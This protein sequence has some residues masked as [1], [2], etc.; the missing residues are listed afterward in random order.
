MKYFNATICVCSLLLCIS[1]GIQD[2][3][4]VNIYVNEEVTSLQHFWR[5][6]G[7]CPPLPHANASSFLLSNDMLQ[8]LLLISSTPHNGIEQVRIHWLLELISKNELS[9]DFKHLDK[10][11]YFLFACGLKPGFEIMGNPSNYFS[12]FDD[13]SQVI[14]FKA[15]VSLIAKRYISMFGLDYVSS[16]NFETWN[17]P[18]HLDFDNVTMTVE[19]FLKYYDA[20]SEGLIEASPSLTFGGPG[21]SCRDPSFSKRCWALFEHVTNGK[22]YI[23][24]KNGSRLDYI[25]FHKKGK[26]NASFILESE[27]DTILKIHKQYPSLTSTPIY[28]DEADPLVGW[29]R[30]QPWRADVVYAAVIVKVI[31][32]HQ[33]QI[34]ANSSGIN[35]ALLSNDNGFLNYFPNYFTQRTLNS[36]FQINNTQPKYVHFVKKP[37]LIVMGLLAKLGDEQISKFYVNDK[38]GGFSSLCVSRSCLNFE[39]STILYNSADTDLSTGLSSVQLNYYNLH[40]TKMFSNGSASNVRAVVCNLNNQDTNPSKIWEQLGKPD[41]PTPSQFVLM[42][43]H[44]GPSCSDPLPVKFNEKGEF[45]TNILIHLPG[46]ALHHICWINASTNGPGKPT[47]L[48]AFNITVG[49]VL[50]TWKDA[51]IGTKCIKTYLVEFAPAFKPAEFAVVNRAKILFN[52]FTYIGF[53]PIAGYF[54]VQA[55]DYWDRKGSYSNTLKYIS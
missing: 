53:N 4:T 12:S 23:T 41:F 26:G 43:E 20:C 14:E 28:N 55:I 37:A 16:W 51:K 22:N 6:T 1:C 50:L 46:V 7:L 8:N 31:S 32:Q 48:S 30:P 19:G 15:L 40:R 34:I 13:M 39:I 5:S 25:S 29:S 24:G 47:N 42:H 9:Y 33:N 38:V 17:E 36:R 52:S 27:L 3:H 54:R 21:G 10:L 35:Y 49:Q 45:S 11:I 2:Q 44:E 18:D